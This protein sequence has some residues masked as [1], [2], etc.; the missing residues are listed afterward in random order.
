MDLKPFFNQ[1]LRDVRIPV[2]EYKIQKDV[3][4]YRW[5]NV[6]DNF[7][8]PMEIIIDEKSTRIYPS[9]QWKEININSEQQPLSIT[10]AMTAMYLF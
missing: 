7:E 6:V 8:M 3:L 9:T 4:K 5:N 10:S 2:F 1:Y